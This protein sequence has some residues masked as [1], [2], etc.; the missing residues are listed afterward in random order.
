M[1]HT[2]DEASHLFDQKRQ[3]LLDERG[4]D[5]RYFCRGTLRVPDDWVRRIGA[6]GLLRDVF[7]ELSG[8]RVSYEKTTHSVAITEWLIEHRPREL[9][10]IADFLVQVLPR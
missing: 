8:A 3:Q 4:R 6:A 10:E 5:F 7:Q 9:G 2:E 1:R